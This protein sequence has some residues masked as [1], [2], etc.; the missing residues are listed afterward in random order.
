MSV[1]PDPKVWAQVCSEAHICTQK[2]CGQNPRCFYQQARKRLL[3]A[4]VIVLNHT[5]LFI[6]LGTPESRKNARAVSCS[7]TISSSSTKLTRSN[8][9][10]RSKSASA[11]RNMDCDRRSNG[12]TTRGR[13]KVSLLSCA[14]PKAYDSRRNWST[15]STNSSMRSS[16]NPIFAKAASFECATSILFPTQSPVGWSALQARIAEVVKRADDEILKAELQEFGRRI[17]DARDGIAIFL[18]QAR[19]NT[20]TGSSAPAKPSASSRSTRRPSI[21]RRS[22]VGCFSVT[23]AAVS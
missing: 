15:T 5:L 21:S 14:R 12:S 7:R 4:D 18:E 16:R 10:P 17:R 23:T 1:E 19:P 20:F 13:E 2:T 6:L 3:A 11:F 9:S 8:R 22:C